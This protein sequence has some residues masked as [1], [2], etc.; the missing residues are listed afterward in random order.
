LKKLQN[1]LN[2]IDAGKDNG[3]ARITKEL[4]FGVEQAKKLKQ[5]LST[6]FDNNGLVNMKGFRQNIEAAGGSMQQFKAEMAGMG[7]AGQMAF[8]SMAVGAY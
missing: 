5:I 8:N 3:A 7:Q 6:S 2:S 4:G 1:G